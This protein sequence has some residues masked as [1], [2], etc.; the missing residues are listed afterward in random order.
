MTPFAYALL[1]LTPVASVFIFLVFLR[2][3]AKR[4]MPVAY[5]IT[6]LVA[7]FFWKVP[8]RQVMAAT[9]EGLV[10]TGTI[11]YIIFGAILLLNTLKGSGAIST[12][13]KGLLDVSPDRRIQAIIIAWFFGAFIEG[14]A[15]FGTPAAIAAPLLL[16]LGF[17]AMAAVVVALII[18]STPVSFGAVGTP[19]L[20]GVNTGL[21]G[22][23]L[24]SARLETLGMEHLEYLTHIGARVGVLHGIIGTLIPLI[25]VSVLTRHFGAKRSWREGFGAWQF[26]LFAGLAFT[27]PYMLTAVFLGPEFPTLFGSMFGLAISVVAARKRWFA[28]KEVWDF[29]PREQ[30]PAF[31]MGTFN[32]EVADGRNRMSLAR[33]WVPYLLVGLCLMLSR[34]NFLP[35]KEALRS[36]KLTWTGILGT[37][38]HA[39]AEV[40]YLPGTIFLGVIAST[41]FIQ[42]MNFA[43]MR[44]A[45]S[46]SVKLLIGTSVALGFA[47]PMTR[48]FIHSGVNTA[49]LE[50]MPIV[51]AETVSGIVGQGWPLIAPSIGAFGA[52]IAGSNTISNMMFSLFQFGVAEKIGVSAAIIVALQAVGGAA[53]NMI[54]VHNVV[55]ASATVGYAGREGILIRAVLLPMFYY[56]L[57][58]GALGFIAV[59]WLKL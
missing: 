45:I 33:A 54:C 18:Q 50:S 24:V 44:I 51:L 9:L 34:L 35:I 57:F 27:I 38:I 15:G 1:A 13:R 48:I 2:W 28:P 53:G 8:G 6:A 25:L 58:A 22:S 56:V 46:D 4:A 23:P 39:S 36:W 26:A 12:I 32:G 55:A 21:K 52:F 11:L 10:I 29:P 20:I 14:V 41:Y 40:L 7:L 3:P 37:N 19:I 49:G 47:V 5:A 42:R 17:P 31:W 30:W 16:A 59:H 43:E